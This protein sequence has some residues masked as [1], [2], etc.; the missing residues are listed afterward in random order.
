MPQCFVVQ[1][2][3]DMI[4]GRIRG[5]IVFVGEMNKLVQIECGAPKAINEILGIVPVP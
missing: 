1:I 2:A 3:T 4:G 5:Q